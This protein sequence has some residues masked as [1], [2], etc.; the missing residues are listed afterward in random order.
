[1][2]KSTLCPCVKWG[3]VLGLDA[4]VACLQIFGISGRTFKNQCRADPHLGSEP[5]IPDSSLLSDSGSQ[6]L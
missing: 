6:S 2:K 5:A 3:C 4:Q 1:M